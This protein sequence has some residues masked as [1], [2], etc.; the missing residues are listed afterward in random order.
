MLR[1]VKASWKLLALVAP[2]VLS[3]ACGSDPRTPTTLAPP[4]NTQMSGTVGAQVPTVP[5]VTLTDQK[6]RALSGVWVKWVVASGAGKVINDSVQTGASGIASSGGWTLGTA[7][8][9][10]TLTANA[11]GLPTVTFTAVAAAGPVSS[12]IQWSAQQ[13]GV[14]NTGLAVAPAV[15]AFDSFSNPVAGVTVTFTV[16]TGGGV[17]SGGTQITGTDGVATATGW[18]LGSIAGDQRL[19]ATASPSG[20]ATTVLAHAVGGVPTQIVLLDG[21]AQVGVSGK[22]LCQPPSVRVLDTFGNTVALVPVTFTPTTGSGTVT[23]ATVVTDT[24]G[25]ATVGSWTLGTGASQT[26]TATAALVAG[27]SVTFTETTAAAPTFSIC[28]RFVGTGGTARQRLAVTRAVARW[29]S[30]IAGHVQTTHL[31]ASATELSTNCAPGLP[32]VDEDIEDLLLFVQLSPIDGPGQILGQ[33]APC[34]IHLPIAI[35]ALG[36]FQLDV[37]D[38][39]LM[40][41]NGT[42]DNVVLHEIGHILGIG[43]LW[44]FRRSFLVGAGTVDSYF[45]G[46][47]TRA[48]FATLGSPFTGN[49]V[50]VENCVGITGCGAGTRDSHWRRS[51]FGNELMNGYAAA[52]MPL[53][54]VTIGSLADLGYTINL[55]AADAFSLLPTA[56]R[57]A[58][59]LAA[60]GAELVNDVKVTQL[61]GIDQGGAKMLL[62][63][64]SSLHR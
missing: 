18:Q 35:T 34:Y 29:Q 20:V 36:F 7:V 30:I 43:T 47:V 64:P 27:K 13:T 63:S 62:G 15:K 49:P 5:S 9:T 4:S 57:G 58:N 52:T 45:A 33:S 1:R 3:V 60:D 2:L 56:L 10:Q 11:A 55:G 32:A 54:V 22:R 51:V 8:G 17:V 42:L 53:S 6:G 44:N 26:L 19:L 39:D 59:L 24:S 21:N 16:A 12:L 50:P 31:T 38:A 23:S 40:L 61:I 28:A 41:N 48:Q 46:A 14:V 25:I 37:A